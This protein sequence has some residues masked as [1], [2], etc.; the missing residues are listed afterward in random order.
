[1][2]KRFITLIC[3]FAVIFTGLAG[4]CAYIALGNAYQISDSYNSYTLNIGTLYTNIYDRTGLKINNNAKRYIAVIR[5]NEKCLNE[6]EK[7]F[8]EEESADITEELSQG[9]PVLRE[10]DKKA[11]TQYIKILEKISDDNAVAK[12]LI[13]KEYGGLEQYVSEEIGTLSVNY[14]VDAVGRL[15]TG[16]DGTIVNDDYDSNDGI[17]ISIDSNNNTQ[18]N[19]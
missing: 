7:L 14:S 8:N 4:R 5:P 1:M 16:D 10:V 12:H 15:L 19:V 11:D 2:G 9:Y 13:K 18:R 6:L 17:I 3:V